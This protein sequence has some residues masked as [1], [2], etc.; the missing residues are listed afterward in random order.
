MS[1]RV[2]VASLD[3]IEVN[4]HFGRANEFLIYD[5]QDET[6]AFLETRRTA[7]SCYNHTHTETRFDRVI[8]LLSDCDAIFVSQIGEGAAAYLIQKGVRVFESPYEIED[9]LQ[10]AIDQKLLETGKGGGKV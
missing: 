5:I 9:V 7:P 1:Y 3:G 2:A 6:Y 4:Q 8:T 10:I